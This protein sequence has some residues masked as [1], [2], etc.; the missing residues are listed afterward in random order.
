MNE[1]THESHHFP[2]VMRALRI[3]RGWSLQDLSRELAARGEHG[4]STATLSRIENAARPT[5]PRERRAILEALDFPPD[6]GEVPLEVALEGA[7]R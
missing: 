5:A 6:L 3:Y 2:R 4:F 7:H 1:T